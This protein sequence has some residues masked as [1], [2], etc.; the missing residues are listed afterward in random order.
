M[1]ERSSN[2]KPRAKRKQSKKALSIRSAADRSRAREP[3]SDE[4]KQQLLQATSVEHRVETICAWMVRGWYQPADYVALARVWGVNERH[5]SQYA[6]EARRMLAREL[7]SKS[8]DELRAE[9]LARMAYI[10]QDALT[11]TE[12]AVTVKGDIVTVRRPD[13]RT[14]LR[15]A[16]AQ[17]E[18][19]GLKVQR[20]HHVITAGELTTEQII[21]QLAAQ[22][23][24]VELP[25]PVLTTG[26]TVTA[27]AEP[28]TKQR[29]EGLA[30]TEER[31][32]A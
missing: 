11:R 16:E 32:D 20:H 31:N 6:A 19:L 30:E 23:V 4:Q 5:A 8:A 27:P 17:S 15:A 12:E 10:G 29:A 7:L 24:R 26:E 2:Q 13:H 21:E 9:L 25:V 14:A 18:L 22:G 28:E 3:Y 1:A